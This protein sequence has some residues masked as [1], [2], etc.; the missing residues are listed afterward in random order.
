MV[1]FQGRTCSVVRRTKRLVRQYLLPLKMD[2][3]GVVLV[4]GELGGPL[5]QYGPF[6]QRYPINLHGKKYRRINSLV[7]RTTEQV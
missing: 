3:L 1:I 2:H 7:R 5:D 4:M 6:S